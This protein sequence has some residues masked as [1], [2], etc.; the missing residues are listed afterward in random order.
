MFVSDKENDY[1]DKAKKTPWPGK[2]IEHTPHARLTMLTVH[3]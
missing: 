1:S 2:H 3:I